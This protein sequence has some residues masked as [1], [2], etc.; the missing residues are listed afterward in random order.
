MIYGRVC[1]NTAALSEPIGLRGTE[2]REFGTYKASFPGALW[3]SKSDIWIVYILYNDI[4]THIYYT[5]SAGTAINIV[6]DSLIDR[7]SVYS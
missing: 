4:F 5:K 6:T 3:L 7:Y 1:D 2:Q